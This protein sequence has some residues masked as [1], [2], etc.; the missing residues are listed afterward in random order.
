MFSNIEPEKLKKRVLTAAL[1]GPISLGLIYYG[2]WPFLLIMAVFFVLAQVEWYYLAKKISGFGWVYPLG[3]LYL[4]FCA[5]CFYLIGIQRS[6]AAL[7]LLV[8][9]ISSDCGAYFAGKIIGGPKMAKKISPNKTWAGLAGA[10]ITPAI[11]LL[12]AEIF[13]LDY[14]FQKSALTYVLFVAFGLLIGLFGQIGD[15]LVSLVKRKAQVKDT[16]T[17]LPGHG[18]VLDRLDSLL[19]AS[20]VFIALEY[21]MGHV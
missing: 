20:P 16:G 2:G 7:L 5:Y 1:I 9:V 10:M 8:L 15:I 13:F 19:L 3:V 14:Y 6:F 17:L 12:L 4:C 21:V 18:G 11:V